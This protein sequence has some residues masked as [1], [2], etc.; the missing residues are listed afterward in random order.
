[1]RLAVGEIPIRDIQF[2]P[3]TEI[4]DGVL[5]I[6]RKELR[7]VILEDENL[8]AAEVDLARPGEN[9][10]IIPVKDV[11]EPR[12]KVEGAGAVFPGIINAASTCGEG[13]THVLRGVCVVTTGRVVGFQEGLIDMSGPGAQHTQ[14]SRILNVVLTC[15][16]AAG[17]DPIAH[18]KAVRLAGLRAA[19]YLAAA[20]KTAAPETVRTYEFEPL[21]GRPTGTGLPRVAYVHMILAQGLLHDN[22]VYGL[23]AKRLFPTLL[24]PTEMQDGA[25]VSGNCV[26]A[27]DKNTTYDQMNNP[28]VEELYRRHG[29]DLDFAGV[30]ITP[31]SPALADKERNSSYV[32]S[33][34]KML[35]T[36]GLVVTE[37]GG[38]NPET[39]LMLLCRKSEQAG[40]RTV[41]FLHENAGEDGASEAITY[42][43][44][45]ADAVVTVG[46]TNEIVLLPPME[47][48]IGHPAAA[49]VL[50]GSSPG[51][52]RSDGSLAV[53]FA[54]IVD[55]VSNLG[56]TKMTARDY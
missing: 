28:V 37:E 42:T 9:V 38:G 14:F 44:P 19:A 15:E 10:R 52:L 31:V 41:L 53:P 2:A 12:V 45:E 29:C 13:T 6:N 5:L 27:C 34:A 36:D 43:T 7:R 47:K 17:L 26:T 1:M 18:E 56:M 46:N 4:R 21:L 55:A 11:I 50:A 54:V 51:A 20:G 24:S 49:D 3:T 8:A 25:I 30:I 35:G 33:L 39:D 32:V 40:I 48:V 22:Y 16:P 23:D